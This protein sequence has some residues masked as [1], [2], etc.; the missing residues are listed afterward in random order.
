MHP[1]LMKRDYLCAP[2]VPMLPRQR[3]HG[4]DELRDLFYV[5]MEF[6][7]PGRPTRHLPWLGESVYFFEGGPHVRCKRKSSDELVVFGVRADP[8]PD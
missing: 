5:A 3:P 2:R 7:G 6:L 8:E 4:R 1:E